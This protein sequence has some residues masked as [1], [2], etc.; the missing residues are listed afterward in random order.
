MVQKAPEINGASLSVVDPGGGFGPSCGMVRPVRAL[1]SLLVLA[2]C[3][4]RAQEAAPLDESAVRQLNADFVRAY[5][6]C[7]VPRF[8]ALLA[9]DFTCVLANGHAMD[10]SEFLRVAKDNLDAHDLRLHDLVIRLYGDTAIVEALAT[11]ERARGTPV[12]TRYSSLYV[13]RDGKWSIVWTQWTRVVEP[14]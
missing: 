9:D 5:I 12:R 14:Q 2:A 6:A 10:K 4:A 3:T 8:R 11:Y 7:D 1:L 13:R